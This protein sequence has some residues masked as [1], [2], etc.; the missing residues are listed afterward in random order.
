MNN[1]PKWRRRFYEMAQLVGTFSKDP[2]RQVGAVIVTEDCRN[3]SI[4]YNG[5]P[6]HVKDLEER[7]RDEER[8]QMMTVH[9]ELNAIYNAR[10]DLRGCTIYSTKFP[11]HECAKG[12]IQSGIT[13][14]VSVPPK[15]YPEGCGTWALSQEFSD[16]M[17]REAGVQMIEVK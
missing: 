8:R 14:I 10:F 5:F 1:A 2:E 12:I 17:L 7:L 3:I 9:A 15:F 13:R 4:G 16:L 11:C 6:R